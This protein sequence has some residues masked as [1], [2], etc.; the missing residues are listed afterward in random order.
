MQILDTFLKLGFFAGG[1][2]LLVR[3]S[4]YLIQSATDVAKEFNVSDLL[5]GLTIVSV[6][7]SLPEVLAS[8]AAL[9]SG[10]ADLAFSNIIGS[11][12]S[13]LTLIVG[14][15]AI[16]APLATNHIVLDRDTKI[17][18][19][20][21]IVTTLMIL[22]PLTL[23][24]I[25][26]IE[27][28]I[29]LTIMIAY[30]SFLYWGRD[31]CDNCYQF[32][33]FVDFFITMRFLTTIRGKAKPP[34]AS[35]RAQNLQDEVLEGKEEKI[36]DRLLAVKRELVIIGVSSI[37]VAIG[38]QWLVDGAE[39]ISMAFGIEESIIGFTIIAFGTSLPE[40][41]ISIKSAKHGYGRLLIGNIVGSNIMNIAMG[42]GFA[43]LFASPPVEIYPAILQL[44]LFFVVS[45]IFYYFIREDWRVT[46]R[47]GA[48]LLILYVVVQVI[49]LT[50][51]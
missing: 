14:I 20:I 51:I 35:K 23:G 42:L 39:Y 45:S 5:I 50:T 3:G 22:N 13:N 16:V 15:S 33:I 10:K 48:I 25:S 21:F 26:I 11:S 34:A 2:V 4:D 28:F 18:I 32:R 36:S 30:L 41:S 44:S 8:I 19:F 31:E 29:L 9:L 27:S 38:A 6:G 7:T 1:L 46:R 43:Y 49:L 12:L 37:A 40:L 24:F 47:E 17:M